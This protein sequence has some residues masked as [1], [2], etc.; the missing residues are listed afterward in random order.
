MLI[1][2][3]QFGLL[4]PTDPIP[5]YDRP[6]ASQ[7]VDALVPLVARQLAATGATRIRFYARPTSTPGWGPYYEVLERACRLRRIRLTVEHL[8]PEFS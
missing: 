7:Y 2:S 5:W 3:G 8:P 4:A 6:L 1:L